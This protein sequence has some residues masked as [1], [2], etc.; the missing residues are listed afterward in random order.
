MKSDGERMRSAV[1]ALQHAQKRLVPMDD[2]PIQELWNI[3]PAPTGAAS[4]RGGTA[5]DAHP[6]LEAVGAEVIFEHGQEH[7]MKDIGSTLSS[8]R[9]Q[10]TGVE[11]F[12]R[13]QTLDQRQRRRRRW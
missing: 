12:R 7:K 8:T 2:D 10:R 6:R 3:P 1:T 11:D 9:R 13:W 4:R 5:S